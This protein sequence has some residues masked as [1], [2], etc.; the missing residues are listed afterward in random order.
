[1]SFK[2]SFVPFFVL[3][4]PSPP[5]PS[6]PAQTGYKNS[7][8]L[9]F[10]LNLRLYLPYHLNQP[11]RATKTRL[12]YL[13]TSSLPSTS[14]TISIQPR[15]ATSTRLGYFFHL[16]LRLYLSTSP[17]ERQALVWGPGVSFL[18]IPPFRLPH[19]LIQLRRATSAHLGYPFT[20]AFTSISLAISSSPD[21]LYKHSSGVF[22][23]R[24]LRLH[25]SYRFNQS[26]TSNR[27]RL[28]FLFT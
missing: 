5:L 21:E 2:R 25:L 1:M 22:F 15:R 27:S 4:L 11:G 8:G 23:H 26:Q 19:Q 7:S 20:S 13:F 10:H 24:A 17:D 12:G 14:L 28:G 16:D 3:A 6:H 9:F 18:L